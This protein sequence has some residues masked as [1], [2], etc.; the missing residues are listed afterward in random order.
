MEDLS[1]EELGI[2][3]LAL[4]FRMPLYKLL[5]EM[6]YQE[7]ALWCKYFKKRPQGQ[8][9]DYRAA[10]I[11][12]AVNPGLPIATVFPS[13]HTD[14]K[15]RSPLKGSLMLSMMRGAKGGERIGGLDEN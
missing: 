5:N 13:L 1:E 8:A 15:P 14:T 4:I 11:M 12:S 6:P 10:M 2:M 3:E 9:E 7:F